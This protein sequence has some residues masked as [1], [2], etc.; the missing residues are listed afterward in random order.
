MLS[1]V[2]CDPDSMPEGDR[3]RTASYPYARIIESTLEVPLMSAQRVTTEYRPQAAQLQLLLQILDESYGRK[4]WHGPNLRGSI[5][6]LTADE[7]NWRP[8]PDRHSIAEIVVHSAYWKYAVR[9]RLRDERRGSFVLKGSNWFALPT[10]L[11][12]SNWRDFVAFL[13]DEH[14]ALREAIAAFPPER[15]DDIPKGGK[16][17]CMTLIHGVAMHDVYHAGQ[18]QLLKRLQIPQAMPKT[19]RA[20][21]TS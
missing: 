14:R 18:I 5:R 4:A 10:S 3:D 17:R 20:A 15:L 11:S 12:Q 6:R 1:R 16:V 21:R 9:R 7:A 8:R 19:A 2:G 13:D